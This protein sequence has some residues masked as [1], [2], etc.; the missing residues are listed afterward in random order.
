[1]AKRNE[2]YTGFKR[3]RILIFG[4][5]FILLFSCDQKQEKNLQDSNIRG[6][7]I[8]SDN[9]DK[10][11]D[12]IRT[13]SEYNINHLQI[14][15][16][17][18][19]K[20]KHLRRDETRKL[21]NELIDSA[22][23]AGIEEVVLW[24]HALYW[25]GYYP[26][27]FKTGPDSTLNLDNPELWE[28]IKQDYR[29]MLDLAPHADG[30]VLT[31]IETGAHIEDQYS[32]KLTSEAEKLALLVNELAKVIIDERD[33]KFYIRTFMYF[34]SE[35]NALLECLDL[36]ENKNIIVMSKEVP[37]DFF[38]THPKT[39]WID[40]ISFPVIVE[41]DCTH[42][43]NGQGV[44]SSIFP[45]VHLERWKYYQSLP[46][47]KGYVARTDRY[48]ESAI[49]G[50]P[51]EINLFALAIALEDSSISADEV[52][53][54]YIVKEYG[55]KAI[56]YL[57]PAFENAYNVVTSVWYTLGLPLSSHS[58]MN[59]DNVWSYTG[60]VSGRWMEEPVTTVEHNVDKQ[61]HYWKDIV[62]HL[63]SPEIKSNKGYLGREILWDRIDKG[64]I[65]T[66]EQMSIEYL[67]YIVTEKDYG[68]ELAQASLK[69]IEKAGDVIEDRQKYEILYHT[70]KRTELSARLY[71]AVAKAYF[72]YR[73]YARGVDYQTEELRNIIYSGLEEAREISGFINNYPD[74]G[75]EASYN[76]QNDAEIAT[77]Y[78]NQISDALALL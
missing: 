59:F 73:V 28:W 38:L 8:L 31:F 77:R 6:W 35:L 52:F 15:H 71:R 14:S 7:T 16:K 36:I 10:A 34:P 51:S 46:N 3:T 55:E 49:V 20:L 18:V 5:M 57:K 12:V 60:M 33:L 45:Q 47:V 58:R 17:I 48:K 24:D 37:H 54:S 53:E 26:D 21:T 39:F 40:D 74:K 25:L 29:E 67:D 23:S 61:F 50:R 66:T 4:W 44:V 72:G 43:Y 62:N 65:D 69:Q 11:L 75:P 19:H 27:K 68:V 42:E 22:H 2:R 13:S 64:W 9:R 78:V 30:I 56:P 76:W 63:A 70:F 32:E 41:F 1:M